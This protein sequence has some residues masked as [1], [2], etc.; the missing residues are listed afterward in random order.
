MKTDNWLNQNRSLGILLL[1]IFVGLRLLYGVVDNIVSWAK[2]ME[3]SI[4]LGN[5]GFPFP[6]VSAVICVYSQFIAGIFILFGYKIRFFSSIMVFNFLVALFFV[7]IPI[8]DTVE[9]MTP[10]LSILFI[11]L[12]FIFTGAEKYSL[13][14]LISRRYER[15]SKSEVPIKKTIPAQ[16]F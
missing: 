1:R 3:F 15:S 4:F 11:C 2:M 16:R 8:K 12:T 9:A 5:F 10:A 14:W 13:D 7:H 6:T